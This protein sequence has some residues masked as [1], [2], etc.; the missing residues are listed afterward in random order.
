[1]AATQ[2]LPVLSDPDQ[3]PRSVCDEL[4]AGAAQREQVDRPETERNS[5]LT[6]F[7]LAAVAGFE[8]FVRRSGK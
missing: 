4:D 8:I 5:V 2:R 1:V 3:A 7:F 6:S